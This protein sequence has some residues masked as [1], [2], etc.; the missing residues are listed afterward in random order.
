MPVGVPGSV[1]LNAD[2][3]HRSWMEN[4][5]ANTPIIASP[6]VNLL[7]ASLVW[8]SVDGHWTTTLAGKNLTNKSYIGAGL[9]IAGTTTVLYPADPRTVSASVRYRF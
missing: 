8:N 4:N 2:V 5:V 9:Y 1:R 7:N 6:A 3:S